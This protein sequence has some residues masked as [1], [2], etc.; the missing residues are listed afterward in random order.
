MQEVI[1]SCMFR[2]LTIFSKVTII[3]TSMLP[4]LTHIASVIPSLTAKRM[5]EI[6]KEW[7]Y[8]IRPNKETIADVKSFYTPEMDKM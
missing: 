7:E 2:Y 6:E 5:E 4:K 8:F 1:N 3:K